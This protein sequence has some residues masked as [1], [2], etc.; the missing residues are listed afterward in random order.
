[1]PIVIKQ[2]GGGEGS[3]AGDCC[4]ISADEWFCLIDL[5]FTNTR[6]NLDALRELKTLTGLRGR[7]AVNLVLTHFHKDHY[8]D[9]K[10][11]SQLQDLKAHLFHF[12]STN[13]QAQQAILKY[14]EDRRTLVESWSELGGTA[15][16]K[17]G[18]DGFT[19]HGLGFSLSIIPPDALKPKLDENDMSMGALF[20]VYANRTQILTFL[21]LGDMT[22]NSA[23]ASVADYLRTY[24]FY[25]GRKLDLIK[26]AHH[27]SEKNLLP[28]LRDVITPN[29][30]RLI[31]SGYT[32]TDTR[33]LCDLLTEAQPKECVLLFENESSRQKFRDYAA[34]RNLLSK[35]ATLATDYVV[36]CGDTGEVSFL[37]EG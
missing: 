20:E 14:F 9:M 1:M 26:L 35:G 27:G 23:N 12:N 10:A 25:Q 29:H 36:T 7:S 30:T 19:R 16:V 4:L 24:G 15:R 8:G 6:Q 11:W 18:T 33:D 3:Y 37:A 17:Q 31:I 32:M 21:T 5:G 13:V 34:L 22:P 28:V 2:F